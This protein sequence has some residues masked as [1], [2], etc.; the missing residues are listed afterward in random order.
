[1]PLYEYRCSICQE[2]V[3]RLGKMDEPTIACPNCSTPNCSVLMNRII[4]IS[5]FHLKGNG[6]YKT[7]YGTNKGKH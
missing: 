2:T 7:D 5:S 4:S 3:E 1:M 6:W